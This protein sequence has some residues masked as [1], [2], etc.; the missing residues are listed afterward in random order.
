MEREPLVVVIDP[1]E[2]LSAISPRL[3]TIAGCRDFA[4]G[5]LSLESIMDAESVSRVRE[6]L[7]GPPVTSR[8][9][10]S[11][12]TLGDGGLPAQAE[13]R[14]TGDGGAVLLVS[15]PP[16]AWTEEDALLLLERSPDLV[17]SLRLRPTVS[18]RYINAAS[19]AVLGY[20]PEEVSAEPYLLVDA[21]HPADC[22]RLEAAFHDPGGLIDPIRFRFR[23]RTG[24]WRW[25]EL[26]AAPVLDENGHVAMIEGIARDVTLRRRLEEQYRLLA[27]RSPEMIYRL[28]VYPTYGMD[29]VSSACEAVTGLP[30]EVYYRDPDLGFQHLHPDD[31]PLFDDLIARPEDYSNRPLQFRFFRPDGRL[32]RTEWVSVPV[33]DEED[34]LIAIEGLCRDVTERQA[35]EEAL[36]LANQKLNLLASI[37]RHDIL[38]Q[39]T[40]LI[41][42]LE[43][44]GAAQDSSDLGWFLSRARTATDVI[45]RLIEFT[46]DYQDIGQGP[47]LW[48][49]VRSSLERAADSFPDRGVAVLIPESETEILA[50]ALI[51][52]VFFTLIENA[53]RHG[54]PL[55]EIRFL[56]ETMPDGSIRIVCEDDGAGIPTPEKPRIFERGQGRNTGFGLYLAREILGI[57]GMSIFETSA[58]GK[59]ARFEITVPA[60]ACRTPVNSVPEQAFGRS[61]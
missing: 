31:R 19:S 6:A 5:A 60:N 32:R 25:L 21:V 35:S 26:S 36:R 59:G 20:G 52:K 9:S 42:S 28:R 47:P 57:T 38:N 16:D 48:V 43:L 8:L 12:V 11:F 56:V 49:S 45:R 54:P 55:S 51:E 33:Y 44:V 39:L 53:L 40:V 23:H 13:L 15:P 1:D 22:V 3:G 30:P 4:P 29:Y 37:T 2:H 58:P 41:G 10:L 50:D 34:R 61:R 17:F 46:R 14:P 27:E 24:A 7:Q 18:V